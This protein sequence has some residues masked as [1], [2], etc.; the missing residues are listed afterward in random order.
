MDTGLLAERFYY[1]AL[2]VAPQ[3]GKWRPTRLPPRSIFQREDNVERAGRPHWR[4][5]G[6]VLG[7]VALCLGCAFSLWNT[8]SGEMRT[9]DLRRRE[10]EGTEEKTAPLPQAPV[11]RGSDTRGTVGAGAAPVHGEAGVCL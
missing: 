2:S 3:I 11:E 7:P 10:A 6:L 8:G 9:L 5:W 4:P 1:Q